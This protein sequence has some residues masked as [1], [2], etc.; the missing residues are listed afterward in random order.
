MKKISRNI[1]LLTTVLLGGLMLACTGA[2]ENN[3]N[4]ENMKTTLNLTKEWDKTFPLS[5]K[6]EHKK[7]TFTNRYGIELAADMYTPKNAQG[8]LAAIAVT[9]PF[10]AVKEQ[11]SGLYAQHMAERG[12]L[13]IAFDPSF[14]GESGG[15]PRRMASPDINTEDFLAAVDFLSVQDNVDPERIG[16]IG[17]CGFGGMAVNAAA[18]DPRIKATVAST[19]YDMSKVNVEGYFA[20]EDTKEQ[21][22]EKRRA[23]AAQRTADYKAGTY[24]RAGGVVDPLPEDAPWFVKDYYDY[25]KTKRGYHERSGNSTDGWNVTGCQSFLNQPILAFASE[26]E[27]PVLL[28]HGEKAHSRYFSEYAFEKM[29][30]KHVEGV[31][32]KDGNKELMIIP[33]ASHVDLYDDKAGVIPYD[34]IETFF[35]ENLK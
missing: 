1:L 28:I 23:M 10:G 16:I 2:N 12:F 34:K 24:K 9:G 30:G 35:K 18:I 33:G 21:R 20:S 5:D 6:V 31:S 3:Q 13:A 14:T 25:Y 4:E 11:S 15:E 22:M 17:I 29:T 19:M 8:K 26:I 32:A 7:V 27:N